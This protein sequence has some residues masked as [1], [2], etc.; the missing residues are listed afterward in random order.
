MSYRAPAID[1]ISLILYN[2]LQRL[3]G[4][5]MKQSKMDSEQKA[6]A[7]DYM[8]ESM[9]KVA[10]MSIFSDDAVS[11]AKE[12]LLIMEAAEEYILDK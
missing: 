8:Y 12:V 9:Q 4:G 7:W 2:G 11:M 5:I 6:E 1:F 3:K 10:T